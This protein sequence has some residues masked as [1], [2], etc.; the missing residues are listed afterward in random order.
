MYCCFAILLITLIPKLFMVHLY[1]IY[2]LQN[3]LVRNQVFMFYY[4]NVSASFFFQLPIFLLL[5]F[6][7]LFLCFLESL[8]FETA[9][10]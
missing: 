3:K 6:T 10:Y 1:F 8:N 5:V 4:Q 7:H 9:N 2:K